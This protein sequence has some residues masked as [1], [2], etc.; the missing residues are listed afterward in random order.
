MLHLGTPLLL[1]SILVLV[2]SGVS[3]FTVTT[4]E[5]SYVHRLSCET[6]VIGVQSA[7]YGRADSVTCS[8][9]QYPHKTSNNH[10]SLLGAAETVKRRCDGKT[11]C[12]LNLVEV[13]N[14]GSDPCRGTYKYLQTKYRCLPSNPVSG[15]YTF[16]DISEEE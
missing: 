15:S 13:S 14:S 3:I 10:C 9:G 11:V 8:E 16:R 6:G 1:A 4:C 7:L 12:E 5:G 2:D